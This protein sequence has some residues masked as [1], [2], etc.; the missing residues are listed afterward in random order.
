MSIIPN[1]FTSLT[2]FFSAHVPFRVPSDEQIVVSIDDMVSYSV[3]PSVNGTTINQPFGTEKLYSFT[4]AIIN[5][6][7]NVDLRVELSTD[8]LLFEA[9]REKIFTL[10][11]GEL[12]EIDITI[13]EDKFNS[14]GGE[15]QIN[16]TFRLKIEN[17]DNGTYAL[18]NLS[19]TRLK[20]FTFPDSIDVE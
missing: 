7:K 20:Q 13:N 12:R 19:L 10:S 2:P 8:E 5:L 3:M 1:T 11:P 17:L 9:V 6:T 4:F 18:K 15:A 16:E 14:I